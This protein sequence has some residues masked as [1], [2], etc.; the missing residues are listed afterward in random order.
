M[1]NFENVKVGDKVVLGYAWHDDIE[2]VIRVTATLFVTKRGYKFRKKDGCE[3][4]RGYVHARYAT[5]EDI[6]R[7]ALERNH[8]ELVRKCG[9]IRFKTLSI[10]QLE[11]ILKIVRMENTE[12]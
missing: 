12:E 9:D 3:Q 8:I 6:E 1:E 2:E 11:D 5:P 10:Q 7:I 4:G